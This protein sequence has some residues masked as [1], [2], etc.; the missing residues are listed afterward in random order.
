MFFI[1]GNFRLGKGPFACCKSVGKNEACKTVTG[2]WENV[3]LLL[4]LNYDQ[5]SQ[6][7]GIL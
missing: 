5:V 2:K 6:Q 7:K 4:L 1:I 3:L